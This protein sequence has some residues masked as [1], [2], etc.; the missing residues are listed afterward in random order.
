M[1]E[2]LRAERRVELAV[3]EAR[4]AGI[5]TLGHAAEQAARIAERAQWRIVALHARAARTLEKQLADHDREASETAGAPPCGERFE[6]A[7]AAVASWL[8]SPHDERE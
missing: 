3:A 1:E 6:Q 2:L 8:T 5:A 4:A 7:L